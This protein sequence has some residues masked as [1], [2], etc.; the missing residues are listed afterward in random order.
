MRLYENWGVMAILIV[1]SL[2][3]TWIAFG[4][5]DEND[6]RPKREVTLGGGVFL[7]SIN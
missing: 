6:E 5:V 2:I 4:C 3:V 1:I 7:R